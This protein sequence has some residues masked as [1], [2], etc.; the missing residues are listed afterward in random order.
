MLFFDKND[1]PVTWQANVLI[2]FQF[3]P[4]KK[5]EK[6]CSICMRTTN[7]RIIWELCLFQVVKT[8]IIHWT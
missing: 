7:F 2:L 4:D 6:N 1:E 5:A 8:K 3:N